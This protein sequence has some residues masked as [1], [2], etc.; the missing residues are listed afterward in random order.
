VKLP[1]I[2]KKI[3][4]FVTSPKELAARVKKIAVGTT[5]AGLALFPMVGASD[6]QGNT[7][8][9]DTRNIETTI[10]NSQNRDNAPK[11][12][13]A[14]EGLGQSALNVLQH[15]SHASHSS[16]SSHYSHRSHYSGF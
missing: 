8:A 13:L 16:H 2:I 11:M 4:E 12:V 5:V 15:V 9:V 1:V 3:S 10:I 7:G 6:Q 14:I